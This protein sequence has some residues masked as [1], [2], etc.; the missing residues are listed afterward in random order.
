MM[1]FGVCV[2]PGCCALDPLLVRLPQPTTGHFQFE[3]PTTTT[4]TNPPAQP[5]GIDTMST[6]EPVIVRTFREH[7][8][9][10]SQTG[11]RR[12]H[13]QRPISTAS[14]HGTGTSG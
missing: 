14:Q 13:C 5:P 1:V 2:G 8:S 9:A 10:P 7:E 6:F 4:T 11:S 12:P 3:V